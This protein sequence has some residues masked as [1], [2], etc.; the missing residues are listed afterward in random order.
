MNTA[1]AIFAAGCF[2]CVEGQFL[3]LKGVMNVESGYIGGDVPHPTYEQVCTGTTQHAEAVRITYD[4]TVVSYEKLVQLFFVAH[5]P[6]QLNRQGNDIGTQYRSAIFPIN[7]EQKKLAEH[8]IYT[9]NNLS[10]IKGK[11]VTTIETGHEF[12]PAEDY[13]T[14]YAERNPQNPY[15]QMVVQPKIKKFIQVLSEDNLLK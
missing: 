8:Y 4:E 11:I 2:W 9:L 13:H 12:Y 7:D 14:N 6:T 15:C 5:D 10:D 1:I 3:Q